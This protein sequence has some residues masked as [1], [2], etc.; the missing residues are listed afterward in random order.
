[1][2]GH[3]QALGSYRVLDLM[4]DGSGLC[5]RLLA[6]WGAEVIKVEPASG[7]A[8][9][10]A[11]PFYRDSP[12]PE[13]SLSWFM[14]NA[15]KK[16]ITL[17]I[18]SRR[19]QELLRSL[20]KSAHFLVESFPPGYLDSLEIGYHRLSKVNPALIMTSITPFGQTG[21]YRDLRASELV[22]EA[23]SGLTYDMGTADRPPVRPAGCGSVSAMCLLGEVQAAAGTLIASYRRLASGQGQHVDVALQECT[24]SLMHFAPMF[25]DMSRIIPTRVGAAIARTTRG[26]T[27]IRRT[28]F[29]CRDGYVEALLLPEW[30]DA[31]VEWMDAEGAASDLKSD[32]H[33]WRVRLSPE[34]DPAITQMEVDHIERLLAGFLARHTKAEVYQQA[35]A[36]GMGWGGVSSIAEVAGDVQLRQRSLFVQV[37]HPELAATL[38][39]A[40]PAW[41]AERTPPFIARRA[42]LVG[43]HN[44]EVYVGESGLSGRD[45][46]MLRESGVI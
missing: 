37:E 17:N 6:E 11:G 16:S 27:T 7:S 44:E 38:T 20:V 14:Y 42:P 1:M 39:V 13:R 36:R 46:V 41:K 24:T 35:E 45:L 19:G 34:A 9:R 31:M 12:H 32:Q 5:P 30:F 43:E 28:V 21:P 29:P 22:T 3:R 25:W 10:T 40:G 15:G 18:Q 33:T 26:V 4:E 8:L 23:L 2:A